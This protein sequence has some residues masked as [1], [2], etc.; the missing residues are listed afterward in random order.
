MAQFMDPPLLWAQSGCAHFLLIYYAQRVVKP[1]LVWPRAFP[2]PHGP[3]RTPTGRSKSF[4]LE[5]TFK[6]TR[7]AEN[8]VN[9]W[10]CRL[11]VA[12]ISSHT[13]K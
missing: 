7:F 6:N 1:A 9:F 3:P 12:D 4:F 5:K 8:L 2:G 11:P 13:S 10:A